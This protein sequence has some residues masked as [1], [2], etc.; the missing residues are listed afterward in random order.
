MNMSDIISFKKLLAFFKIQL[1]CE[2]LKLW[3]DRFYKIM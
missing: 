3:E 1:Q 2:H